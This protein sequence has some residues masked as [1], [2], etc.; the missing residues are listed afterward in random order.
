MPENGN[1]PDDE[2]PAHVRS[3]RIY[4]AEDTILSETKPYRLSIFLSA[5]EGKACLAAFDLPS[6]VFRNGSL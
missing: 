2:E 1:K 6:G 4:P 5:C 3:E